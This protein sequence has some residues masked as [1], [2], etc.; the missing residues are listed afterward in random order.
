MA[1]A[2]AEVMTVATAAAMAAVTTATVTSTARAVARALCTVRIPQSMLKMD[3]QFESNLA[4]QTKSII[5][6]SP[7]EA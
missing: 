7:V 1:A 4:S 6:N 3:V 2:R 5:E